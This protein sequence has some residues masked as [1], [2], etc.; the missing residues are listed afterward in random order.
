[1]ESDFESE[2]LLHP[3]G[4][5][6]VDNNN[7]SNKNK[8]NSNNRYSIVLLTIIAGLISLLILSYYYQSD[9]NNSILN[10]HISNNSTNNIIPINTVHNVLPDSITT[11]TT[12]STLYPQAQYH[13]YIVSNCGSGRYN[14]SV[15]NLERGFPGLFIFHCFQYVPHTDNRIDPSWGERDKKIRSSTLGFQDIWK[16]EIPKHSSNPSDWNFV[17]ED[18]VNVVNPA[19]F[20]EETEEGKNYTLH[21]NGER[22]LT[23][24][25]DMLRDALYNPTVW[26]KDGAVYL[27]ICL[28]PN[29]NHR[30]FTNN[31]LKY[32][33][34]IIHHYRAVG[35][36]AHAMGITTWRARIFWDE[37]LNAVA[38]S[39][40]CMDEYF[41]HWNAVIGPHFYV[42]GSNMDAPKGT[43]HYGIVYQ[44]R[45]AHPSLIGW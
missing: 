12:T 36:C 11:I 42:L 32:H 21:H 39:A 34:N 1:M 16:I 14:F 23:N 7:Q 40:S 26:S 15:A 4:S 35:R 18:D 3:N 13:A 5:N 22:P 20:Y 2:L 30:E 17:F 27:G 29:I 45:D 19:R 31:P 10:H 8:Y 6:S 41:D 25:N 38:F 33:D 37:N 28:N 9:C 44:D 43:G 24:Y